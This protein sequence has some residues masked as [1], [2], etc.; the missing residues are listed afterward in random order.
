MTVAKHQPSFAAGEISPLL[1]GRV[2]LVRFD[3]GL[4]K[5]R[6]MIVLVHGGAAFRP[7]TRFVNEARD[8]NNPCR[9]IPFVFNEE[10]AYVVEASAGKA[11][12]YRDKAVLLESAGG[13][14]FEIDTPLTQAELPLVQWAQSGD[15]L[16]VASAAQP[17]FRLN[18]F[19]DTN[20]T[21]TTPDFAGGPLLPQNIDE[22]KTIQASGVTGTVTLTAAGFTFSAGHVGALWQIE[23]KDAGNEPLWLGGIDGD[24]PVTYAL[25]AKVRASGRV[26]ESAS[27]NGTEAGT[28][29]PV[30]DEGTV[31]S[32]PG[33]VEWTFLHNGR[34]LVKITA[35]AGDGVTATATVLKRLPDQLIGTASYK[36][37]EGAWSIARGFP[38]V[39]DFYEQRLMLGSSPSEPQAV[40][41]SVTADFENFEEGVADDQA[42]QFRILSRDNRGSPIRWFTGTDVLAVGTART[43][44]AVAGGDLSAPLSPTNIAAR[45]Q[46][47]NGS[48]QVPPVALDFP[49]YVSAD[50]RRVY[51]MAFDVT[52]NKRPSTELSLFSEHITQSGIVEMHWQQ[53][54]WRTLWCVLGDGALAGM[55]YDR[56]QQ[57]LAWHRHD[58]AGGAVES[59]AVIPAQNGKTDQLWLAVRR[60]VNG[61]TKRF[62][63][64]LEDPLSFT[65]SG[66]AADAWHLDSALQ[67]DGP[68]V[69][70]VSGLDH[71]EGES[72]AI[73]ADGAVHAPRVVTAGAVGLDAPAS[74]VL[75]GLAYSGQITSLN[76]E[77]QFGDGSTAGRARR[78]KELV[79]RATGSIGGTARVE[80][81]QFTELLKPSGGGVMN[82]ALQLFE[83]IVTAR[84]GV[85]F[86][87]NRA[88]TVEQTAPLPLTVLAITPV[89]KIAGVNDAGGPG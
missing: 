20:W 74:K 58:L 79:V 19:G 4:A 26:Y 60:V 30:H 42:I 72:V 24:L 77:F 81:S 46:S 21:I 3:Q 37:R 5:A 18:R 51:E 66:T 23:E 9:L 28:N 64:V 2:D 49:I 82:A 75:V 86:D 57:V 12:F 13:P 62:I 38:G 65:A 54:P 10:Q 56:S 40:W 45:P 35:V 25:G 44:F 39:I 16:Y 22:S 70:S 87:L 59:A 50:A 76:P 6:N 63:E 15:V 36:W 67:Y 71:L 88:I 34:G 52:S 11:R 8:Q 31:E 80:G 53:V 84:F 47:N 69:G 55:S 17:T 85:G 83:G 29:P 78:I 7:G 89:W 33:K 27:A 61:A 73:L 1:F 14:I 41:G 43:E 48:A 68:A 32:G